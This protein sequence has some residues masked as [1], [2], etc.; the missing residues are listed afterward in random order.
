MNLILSEKKINFRIYDVLTIKLSE[1]TQINNKTM[2]MFQHAINWVEIPV[3]DFERAKKFY[4][5]IYDYEMPEMMMGPNRMGFLLFDRANGGIGAAIVKGE[6]YLPSPQGIKVYLNAGSG[7]DT[8]LDRVV[9]AG[10]KVLLPKTLIA[11]DMGFMASFEDTEG[12]IISLH[13]T[14]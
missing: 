14:A 4:S 5:T 8:I 3:S 9:S 10:G 6:G 2:E 12:N 7:L 11:P 13:G 1:I